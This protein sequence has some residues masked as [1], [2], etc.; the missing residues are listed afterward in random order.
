MGT[1]EQWRDRCACFEKQAFDLRREVTSLRAEN[2]RLR[3]LAYITI[4]LPRWWPGRKAA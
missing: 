4:K 1:R 2:E 3:R